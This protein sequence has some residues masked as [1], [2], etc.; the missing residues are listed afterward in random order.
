MKPKSQRLTLLLLAA[1]AVLGAVLLAMSA[2]KDQA[3]YF[4]APGDLAR[5][6]T[7]PTGAVRIGGMVQKGSIRRAPDGVTIEFV[8]TD[9]TPNRLRVRYRGIVPDL[10]KEG[11]GVVAEGRFAPGGLF[12]ADEIL[13]KHDENYRPPELVGAK[14]EHK[15][16]SL[17]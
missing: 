16:E 10:F 2:L 11:S 14:G 9:E 13:A 7:L 1:A 12:V 3:A 15:S 4:Y 6:G 17:R 5:Q 8:V